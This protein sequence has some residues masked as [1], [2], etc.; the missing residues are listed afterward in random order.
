[1]D[2]TF[3]EDS[4]YKKSRKRPTKEPKET[5]APRIHDTTMNKETQEEDREFEE[6]QECRS[7]SGEESSQEETC[8]GTR[9]YPRC[10]KIWDSRRESQR[11]KEDQ[12]LLRV[13]SF[14]V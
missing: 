9:S 6:P 13:C 11:K 5:K 12:V 7:T 1:M 14:N 8:L 3:D 4:V 10:G 2:V